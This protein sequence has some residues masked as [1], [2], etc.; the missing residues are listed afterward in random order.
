MAFHCYF[1]KNLVFNNVTCY[2]ASNHVFVSKCAMKPR[3]ARLDCVLLIAPRRQPLLPCIFW[4]LM[5][6]TCV[7]SQCERVLQVVSANPF[8]FELRGIYMALYVKSALEMVSAQSTL[9]YL[10]VG[11]ESSYPSSPV[12]LWMLPLSLDNV[13]AGCAV[14]GVCIC[15]CAFLSLIKFQSQIEFIFG[16]SPWKNY[17]CLFSN[18][19]RRELS[20][21]Y[22]YTSSSKA[23]STQG[24]WFASI[25]PEWQGD[26]LPREAILWVITA[27]QPK[28]QYSRVSESKRCSFFSPCL[29]SWTANRHVM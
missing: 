7:S 16:D 21:T 29:I 15:V 9:F 12:L 10:S 25:Y 19:N 3:V 26:F 17:P 11:S 14:G 18:T 20:V 4:T 8:A 13:K 1:R 5:L 24:L 6:V 27:M 22:F 2:F 23:S 28:Q